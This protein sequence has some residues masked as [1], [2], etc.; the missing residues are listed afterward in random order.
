MLYRSY[1]A[2]GATLVGIALAGLGLQWAIGRA[3]F[4]TTDPTD[5]LVASTIE[6]SFDRFDD[7][8]QTEGTTNHPSGS[9]A[10]VDEAKAAPSPLLVAGAAGLAIVGLGFGGA[11]V[12][13]RREAPS[14][15]HPAP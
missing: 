9:P 8:A 14:P 3:V 15:D 2:G 13:L 1:K 10:T 4:G 7:P 12:L 11:M 6:G 5:A